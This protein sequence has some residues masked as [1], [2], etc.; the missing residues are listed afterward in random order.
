[1][2]LISEWEGLNNKLFRIVASE[3]SAERVIEP[4]KLYNNIYL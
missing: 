1:M 2:H 4:C 3:R